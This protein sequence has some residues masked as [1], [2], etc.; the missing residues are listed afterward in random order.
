[1]QE[2]ARKDIER[3]FGVLQQRWAIVKNPCRQWDL[4]T[5]T[6][7]MLA[8]VILH[9]MIIEDEKDC[10]L[11]SLFENDVLLQPRTS[12]FTFRD[13]QQGIRDVEDITQHYNLRNDLMDHL[14]QKRGDESF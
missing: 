13:L 4:D 1:M 7:I 2:A 11:E 3:A 10:N 8:C 14:W 5:I 6:D 9:N 12:D